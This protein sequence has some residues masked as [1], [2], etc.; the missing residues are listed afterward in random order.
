M[1][2]RTEALQLLEAYL[3]T[4]PQEAPFLQMAAELASQDSATQE[5]ALAY[6]KRLYALNP[7]DEEIR[8]RLLDL[9][10]ASGRFAEAIPLQEQVVADSPDNPQALHQLA[11]LYAWQRDY[12]A[13][14][15]IYQKL[16]ELEAGNQALRLEA[17]KNAEAAHNP[18]QALAHYLRLYAQTGGQKEYALILARLWSQKG[19]HAE[20]AAVLAPLMDQNPSL[21][22]RRRYALELLLAQQLRPVPEGLPPGLGSRRLPQRNHP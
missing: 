4:H 14:L 15:P 16:L 20:A 7:Q 6:Y 21:E 2:K 5:Q 10:T 8:Q 19:Q 11:L 22:E 18:E 1:E 9:L 13:A 17:A 12:Q 3:T